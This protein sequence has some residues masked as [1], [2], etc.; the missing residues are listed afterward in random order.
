MTSRSPGRRAMEDE[1]HRKEASKHSC[2]DCWSVLRRPAP[3]TAG[4]HPP[5]DAEEDDAFYA[6]TLSATLTSLRIRLG[7]AK[8]VSGGPGSEL[9]KEEIGKIADWS[10]YNWL[11]YINNFVK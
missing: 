4:Q 2:A 9:G 8:K 3:N 7:M 1:A 5:A 6:F 10:F 11:I